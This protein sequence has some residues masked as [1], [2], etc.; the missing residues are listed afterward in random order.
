[1]TGPLAGVR[2]LDLTHFVAGPWC[3][4]LLADLGAEVTKLEPP[5][6]EIGRGMGSVY[7]GGE[8]AI[9]LGFNR[10]KRSISLD[11]KHPAGLE[12][13]LQL[14]EQSDVVVQNFRPGTAE[15]L[16]LGAA[17]LRAKYPALIYC[18][19]SAFGPDGPYST[20]PANDPVIQA[21]SG[22][23]AS[24]GQLGG[25]PVRMGVSLPDVGAGVLAAV[26][27]LAALYRRAGSGTGSTID[28]NLL[29]TQLYAQTDQLGNTDSNRVQP[30]SI[31]GPYICGDG[32]SLWV[33]SDGESR[34]AAGLQSQASVGSEMNRGQVAEILCTRPRAHWLELLGPEGTGVV[35][36]LGLSDVL[37]GAPHRTLEVQHPT[38]GTL[39]Q[40]RTPVE[41]DPPWPLVD[42]PPPRLGE[43]TWAVLHQLGLPN[44]D[45]DRLVSQGAARGP[46][47]HP[48]AP[49]PTNTK[50]THAKE[51]S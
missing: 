41:A 5:A 50:E 23:M 34:V 38:V 37:P 21:L 17:E 45:I 25:R 18:T 30:P 8:S 16:G 40:V 31:Q 3:T 7:S 46:G 48:T 13:A 24:T 39:R 15:R 2:V 43:H 27:I 35:P 47:D 36:V 10:G 12:A 14:V 6:G 29:D 20:L 44:G 19:V 22:S 4:M 26:G 33:D 51:Q 1:M 9:F 11:L 28:L 42:T 32:L 49:H